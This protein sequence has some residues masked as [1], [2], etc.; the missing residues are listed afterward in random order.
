MWKNDKNVAFKGEVEINL[1][2]Q[3]PVF[4]QQYL[5]QGYMHSQ[6]LRVFNKMFSFPNYDSK[7][8]H[9]HYT[10][11]SDIYRRYMYDLLMFLEPR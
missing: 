11:E 8:K 10:W 4:L 7:N 6:F 1:L 2:N 9:A 5:L 3:M